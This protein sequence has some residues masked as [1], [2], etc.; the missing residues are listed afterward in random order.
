MLVIYLIIAQ[1]NVM[2]IGV[3]AMERIPLGIVVVF[4]M[5][6][7]EFVHLSVSL[8]VVVRLAILIVDVIKYVTP[9]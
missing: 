6:L 9:K 1:A 2:V 3:D 4:A 5:G 8:N 7:V